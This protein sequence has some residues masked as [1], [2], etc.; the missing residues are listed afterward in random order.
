MSRLRRKALDYQGG[1]GPI[2]RTSESSRQMRQ[3]PLSVWSLIFVLALLFPLRLDYAWWFFSTV[4]I[5][6]VVLSG[7]FFVVMFVAVLRGRIDLGDRRVFVLLAL[8]VLFAIASLAWSIELR[9]T[10]KSIVVYGAALATFLVTVALLKDVSV[11]ALVL[12]VLLLPIALIVT[13]VLS[14]L[15]NSVL[16]PELV[17][18]S[19][20]LLQDGFVLSYRARFS[21][22]FLGLSN[23]FA[24][25]LAM[26]LPL[27]LLVRRL[28][29]LRQWSWFVAVLTLAAVIA[30]GSRGVILAVVLAFGVVFFWRLVL[31][32]RVPLRGIFLMIVAAVL[33]AGFIWG[34]PVAREYLADRVSTRNIES[35]LHAFSA[36]FEVLRGHPQG[37]GSGVYFGSVSDVP[38]RSVHNS[39]LQNLLWFG[40]VAGLL[41]TIA[42]WFLPLVILRMRTLTEPARY[43][44]QAL[45]L[46]VL[47]LLFINLSQASW[48][49]SVIRIWV[50]F[51]IALGVMVVRQVDRASRGK[52]I[53]EG[54]YA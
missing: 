32:G 43:V 51:L 23:S 14:Y 15:P 9:E 6:E 7:L 39:Y 24:T 2:A 20:V 21:H 46:S 22:P 40:W 38:L 4:S 16:R 53:S 17:M 28:G 29:F 26:L 48:E 49:G 8:P 41:L 19:G 47:T 1:G 31:R 27:V 50:Y 36:A 10:I 11:R 5:L 45:A 44:K 13:A 35:R 34:N 30:T 33:A 54:G 42:M 3:S 18:P 25:I 52:A 37:V 12:L